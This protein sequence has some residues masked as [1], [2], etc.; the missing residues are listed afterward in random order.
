M[1]ATSTTQRQTMKTNGGLWSTS[2]TP[3]SPKLVL[4]P[5]RHPGEDRAG[6]KASTS[7]ASTTAVKRRRKQGIA[8]NGVLVACSFHPQTRY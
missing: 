2:S 8:N 1:I 7:N 3:R 6:A 5:A 4:T